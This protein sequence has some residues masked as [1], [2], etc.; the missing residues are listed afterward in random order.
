MVLSLCFTHATSGRRK[1]GSG[2]KLKWMCAVGQFWW[3]HVLSVPHCHSII[4][5][6]SFE[7]WGSEQEV[8]EINP[9]WRTKILWFTAWLNKDPVILAFKNNEYYPKEVRDPSKFVPVILNV[10]PAFQDMVVVVVVVVVV[11]LEVVLVSRMFL[12]VFSLLLVLVSR[13]VFVG[14]QVVVGPGFQDVVVAGGPGFQDVLVGFQVVVGPGF[15]DVVVAGGR[16]LLVFRLLL[17][18]FAG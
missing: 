2:L 17:S 12:L 9:E 8:I 4:D 11:V 7:P 6:R 15:Q 14:S 16:L 18:C 5:S 3:W 10:D 13:T 1:K